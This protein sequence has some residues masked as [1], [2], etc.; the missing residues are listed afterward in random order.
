MKKHLLSLF[1]IFKEGDALIRAMKVK[2]V[3][4]NLKALILLKQH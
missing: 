4:R 1:G 3:E 2:C